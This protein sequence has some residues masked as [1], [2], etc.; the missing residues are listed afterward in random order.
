MRRRFARRGGGDAVANAVLDGGEF[1]ETH[2][3]EKRGVYSADAASDSAL[4]LLGRKLISVKIDRRNPSVRYS[5][6]I[7]AGGLLLIS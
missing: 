1:L 6:S 5:H 4:G 7:V 2:A 3:T